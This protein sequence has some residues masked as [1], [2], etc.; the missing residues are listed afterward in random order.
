[1]ARPE[2]FEPPTLCLEG[3]QLV[4]EAKTTVYGSRHVFS[5]PMEAQNSSGTFAMAPTP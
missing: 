3:S 1:M 4:Q 5:E 2:G